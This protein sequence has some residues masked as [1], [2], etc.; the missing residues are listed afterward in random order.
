MRPK[1][2]SFRYLRSRGQVLC[3]GAHAEGHC[4][5]ALQEQERVERTQRRP[6]VAQERDTRLQDLGDETKRLYCPAAWVQTASGQT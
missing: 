3:D 5:D 1:S 4:L 6:Q 2:T